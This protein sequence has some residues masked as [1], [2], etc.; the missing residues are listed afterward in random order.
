MMQMLHAAS[1]LL[2]P[3]HSGDAVLPLCNYI[4]LCHIFFKTKYYLILCTLAEKPPRKGE[5]SKILDMGTW[6]LLRYCNDQ[7][8]ISSR[9][10]VE[11]ITSFPLLT[12]N[13][14]GQ[15]G[16]MASPTQWTWVWAISRWRTG[17]PGV[18]QSMGCKESDM[19]ERLNISLW[20][21]YIQYHACQN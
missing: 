6:M 12:C 7:S 17:K 18:L 16:W 21:T 8:L 4:C 2:D 10:D 20:T 19:T 15:D 5:K 3:S 9:K 1:H 13:N 14:R 11:C